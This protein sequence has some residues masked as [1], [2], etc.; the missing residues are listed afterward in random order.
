MLIRIRTLI[1]TDADTNADAGTV[2]ATGRALL[3]RKLTREVA[4]A[5]TEVGLT[6]RTYGQIGRGGRVDAASTDADS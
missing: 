4:E 2:P 6:I 5:G 1:L 3:L